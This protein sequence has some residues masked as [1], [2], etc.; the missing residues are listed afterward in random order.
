MTNAFKEF[1]KSD[2]N[3]LTSEHTLLQFSYKVF[4]AIPE[5]IS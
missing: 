4:G 3:D 2:D 1:H 5:V